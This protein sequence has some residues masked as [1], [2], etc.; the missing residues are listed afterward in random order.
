MLDCNPGTGRPEVAGV[1]PFNE[2]N[3]CPDNHV[4]CADYSQ[5][6]VGRW[7]DPLDV[8]VDPFTKALRGAIEIVV[9]V[10]CDVS[11]AHLDAIAVG[12]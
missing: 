4:V 8:I 6:I 11:V 5:V 2:A 10:T 1:A 7:N 9:F 3:H 12:E